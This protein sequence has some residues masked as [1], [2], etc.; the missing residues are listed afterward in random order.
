MAYVGN[1]ERLCRAIVEH[2]LKEVKDWLQQENSDPNTRDYTGRTPLQLACVTSTPEIVQ[3]LVD[4]GARLIARIADGRTALH[5]AAARGSPEIVRILLTKSEQNEED[6]AKKEDIRKYEQEQETRMAR[7]ATSGE[8]NEH[9]EEHDLV[10]MSDSRSTTS[11]R[12]IGSFVKVDVPEADKA[13]DNLLEGENELEPDIY[14]VNVLAWDNH[15]SPLHLAILGGHTDVVEELVASFGADVLLPIKLLKSYN[16][17]PGAAIL[18][19]V[20][21]LRLPLEKAKAMTEKLLRLG[22]SPAQADLHSRTPLHYLAATGYTDLLDIYLKH[23][24]PAVK[25]VINHLAAKGYAYRPDVYSAFTTAVDAGDAIG[26]VKLLDSGAEPSIAFDGFIKSAQAKFER[27]KQNSSEENE[28]LF[29]EHVRQP[30]ITAV[31]KDMPLLA[32]EILARGAEPNTLTQNGHMVKTQARNRNYMEGKS[33][34]DCVRGKL[35]ALRNYNGEDFENCLPLT[36]LDA[37][38]NTYLNGLHEGT[39]RMWTA[40]HALKQARAEYKKKQE[41][42]EKKKQEAENRRGMA[43]KVAA[44]KAHLQDFEKL[45]HALLEKGGKT[46]KELFPDIKPPTQRN[47]R[48]Y[49]REP[50]P[51]E[52]KFSFGVPDLTPLKREG[53]IRLFVKGYPLLA[54]NC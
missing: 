21:T 1:T 4:H 25:R 43:E 47:Y 34:L 49:T 51:F 10:V 32:L 7:G 22:A 38:D 3:C 17:S 20:L 2:N 35:T 33:L 29:G 26:A 53:Y 42:H 30:I 19:L 45:E 18:T 50:T 54:A 46:F 13:S 28:S 48:N 9:Q 44:V 37:D 23:D 40:Q 39:Y 12:T 6:E 27:L 36:P 52:I 41:Q 16:N 11:S 24:Q 31:E 15:T 8:A 5:L 14:D